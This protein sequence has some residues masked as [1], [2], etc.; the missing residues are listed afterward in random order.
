MDDTLVL[1]AAQNRIATMS[2][3]YMDQ[4][5]YAP[6]Q[7]KGMPGQNIDFGPGAIIDVPSD[8]EIGRVG[9]APIQP[10]VL[11]VI[12]NLERDSRA[13]GRNPISRSGESPSSV[14]SAPVVEALMGGMSTEV[15]ALQVQ[16]AH[17]LV[18]AN[19]V[20]QLVDVAYCDA[21]K[22]VVGF[23]EGG[24]FKLSYTPSSAIKPGDISNRVFYGAAAGVGEFNRELVVLRRRGVVSDR[25]I[26]E[27]LAG[28]ENPL[29]EENRLLDE[30]ALNALLQGVLAAASQGDLA[31]LAALQEARAKNENPLLVVP[32]IVASQGSAAPPLGAPSTPA[33]PLALPGEATP[34]QQSAA[35]AAQGLPPLAQL[36]G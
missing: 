33:Q 5:V 30:A 15:K 7:K 26:R 34:G 9:P 18:Q 25:W 17:A 1:L 16:M 23:A 28:V 24:Q 36:T 13:S 6:I 21:K 35:Q 11:Q 2:I 8:G 27:N 31:P 14:V 20:A 32:M 29:R 10:G 12:Q 19:E 4:A 22:S 3:D